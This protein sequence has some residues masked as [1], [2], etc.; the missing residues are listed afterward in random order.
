METGAIEPS[1]GDEAELLRTLRGDGGVAAGA[2]VRLER[3]PWCRRGLA[4]A[5]PR[6]GFR[7]CLDC[8]LLD[9]YGRPVSHHPRTPAP[10]RV[11]RSRGFHIR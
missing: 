11:R 10:K 5:L 6:G 9:V 8:G 3:C 2:S 7:V 4:I 1:G